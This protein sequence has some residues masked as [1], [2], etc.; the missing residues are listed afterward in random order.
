MWSLFYNAVV[1][2]EVTVCERFLSQRSEELCGLTQGEIPI[3]RGVEPSVEPSGRS[4]HVCKHLPMDSHTVLG[5]LSPLIALNVP[6][7]AQGGAGGDGG[8][9]RTLIQGLAL[10]ERFTV[11]LQGK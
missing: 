11:A 3:M 2:I 8:H 5:R 6:L 1:I 9:V 7:T 4:W 10:D